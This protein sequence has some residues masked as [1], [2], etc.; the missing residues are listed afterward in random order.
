MKWFMRFAVPRPNIEA[1]IISVTPLPGV[2]AGSALVAHEGRLLVIQDDTASVVWID[3][4]SLQTERV[5][6]EGSGEQ[7]EKKSKPDFE[8]AFFGPGQAITILGSGSSPK[9]QRRA[10]LDL[11]SNEVRL[12]DETRLFEALGNALGTVPNLEGGVIWENRL[13]LFHRGSGPVPSAIVDVNLDVL[14]GAEP[15]ISA[16]TQVDL[17]RV[18]GIP[19][20]FTDATT[21]KGT[22]FYTAVAEDTPNAIDDGP[23]VGAVVGFI[24]G[25]HLTWTPLLEP[26]GEKTTRKVEGLAFETYSTSGTLFGVTDPDD[27]EKPAELLQIELVE[28]I[29]YD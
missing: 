20:Q 8:V 10:V 28:V 5:V 26:S 25:E 9:R 16:V 12:F 29:R 1:R 17:D 21:Y 15:E 7:L 19:L 24:E 18:N 27:P 3:P 14:Q 23:V 4:S 6:L 11:E 13:R 2:H 22:I